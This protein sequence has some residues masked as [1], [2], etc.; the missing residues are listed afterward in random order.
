MLL[1]LT[2]DISIVVVVGIIII[3]DIYAEYTGGRASNIYTSVGC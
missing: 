3:N 2:V 1:F